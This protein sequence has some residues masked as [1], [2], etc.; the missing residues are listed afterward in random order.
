VTTIALLVRNGTE[1]KPI[2]AIKPARNVTSMAS[3]CIYWPHPTLNLAQ[4]AP[5]F[6]WHQAVW[7]MSKDWTSS[8]LTCQNRARSSAIKPTTTMNWKM[9][10][11]RPTYI[12]C[13]CV[14]KTPSVL[15]LLGCVICRRTFA[16]P[17]RRPAV[18]VPFGRERLLPKSIHAVTA[19]GFELKLVLFVLALSISRLPL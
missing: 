6:S 11:S 14:S 9:S 5:G 10:C 12:S 17:L 15:F 3:K 4:R 8:T 7:G 2:A 13:R 16:R 18:R 19:E 1:V